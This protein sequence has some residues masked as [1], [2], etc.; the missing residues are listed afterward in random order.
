MRQS[1]NAKWIAVVAVIIIV[2]FWLVGWFW[3]MSPDTFDVRKRLAEN[4]TVENPTSIAGYTITT[5]MIDVSETLLDKP[6]GYLS[7]DVTPPGIFLDNMPAWEFGAL[8]M[9]RDLAL[10]MRK[11]FSR[12]QS[13][14]IENVFLTKAH[15]KFNMDH[16]S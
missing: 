9:V 11:D 3:S 12:S 10:S 14:S 15:P 2:L 8:E 4:S 7:N 13:Q 5:T 6:G 16:K 1:L